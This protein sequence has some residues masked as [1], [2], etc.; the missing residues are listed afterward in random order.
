MF[1]QTR[2]SLWREYKRLTTEQNITKSLKYIK[3]SSQELLD[4][5]NKIKT[6]ATV[7]LSSND[8][9]HRTVVEKRRLARDL[10]IARYKLDKT[11]NP[12]SQ[13][14]ERVNKL[15][16]TINQPNITMERLGL[17]Y[18]TSSLADIEMAL[19]WLNKS[20]KERATM[21]LP[22]L[23]PVIRGRNRETHLLWVELMNLLNVN[24]DTDISSIPVNKKSSKEDIQELIQRIRNGEYTYNIS[25]N[26]L[27]IERNNELSE[28]SFAFRTFDKLTRE[29]IMSIIES[30]FR[31]TNI[32]SRT[33]VD[34]KIYHRQT[35][36]FDSSLGWIKPQDFKMSY[37]KITKAGT[38]TQFADLPLYSDA[39]LEYYSL[40]SG[41]QWKQN[42]CVLNMLMT[43][44][45]HERG[46]SQLTRAVLE[47][48]LGT[49]SPSANQLHEWLKRKDISHILQDPLNNVLLRYVSTHNNVKPIYGKIINSHI[50]TYTNDDTINAL[51]SSAD[52][53][54]CLRVDYSKSH[55]IHN[56]FYDMET[57]FDCIIHDILSTCESTKDN[58]STQNV[59]IVA[60]G[61]LSSLNDVV[62]YL[63]K[64]TGVCCEN[65]YGSSNKISGFTYKHLFVEISAWGASESII[66]AIKEKHPNSLIEYENQ[67]VSKIAEFIFSQFIKRQ[68]SYNKHTEKY[69]N[70]IIPLIQNKV[71]VDN[72][73]PSARAYDIAKCYKSCFMNRDEPFY[74]VNASDD[75][76]KVDFTEFPEQFKLGYYLIESPKPICLS[77]FSIASKNTIG[78]Y[79]LVVRS[80]DL[81]RLAE[82]G[83]ITPRDIK[84]FLA[85]R[86]MLN[87]SIAREMVNYIDELPINSPEAKKQIF[88]SYTGTLGKNTCKKSVMNC[89]TDL[90]SVHALLSEKVINTYKQILG[91]E[92]DMTYDKH[93]QLYLIENTTET[94][95]EK[96]NRPIY[97][98][99]LIS[100]IF[101]LERLYKAL[102]SP[103]SKVLYYKTDCICMTHTKCITLGTNA[104]DYREEQIKEKLVVSKEDKIVDYIQSPTDWVDISKYIDGN[105]YI[106][107]MYLKALID[108]RISF[109][110]Q[111]KGGRGK[112]HII[113]KLMKHVKC[114]GLTL[115]HQARIQLT[116]SGI[117]NSLTF[118]SFFATNPSEG[119]N[120][121]VD[122]IL[123]KLS[124]IDYIVV[125]ELS[126]VSSMF[127]NEL[128]MFWKKKQFNVIML[129]D[130]HQLCPPENG[131]RNNFNTTVVKEMCQYR[132]IELL[133]NYRS[134]ERLDKIAE[135]A[136]NGSRIEICPFK[137]AHTLKRINIC[138]TNARRKA[139]NDAC[140]ATFCKERDELG[141][142]EGVPFI[143]R[144]NE[145]NINNG[146]RYL[147]KKYSNG[148]VHL[149]S[150]FDNNSTLDLKKE[151]FKKIFDLAYCTTVHCAQGAT[152]N[153]EYTIHELKRFD[154][155]LA[156]TAF[157]RATKLENIYIDGSW[158]EIF[159]ESEDE[160]STIDITQKDKEMSI[161]TLGIRAFTKSNTSI[162]RKV[163]YIGQ[164]N[165]TENRFAQHLECARDVNNH[166]QVYEF[167]R[168]INTDDIDMQIVATCHKDNSDEFEYNVINYY[169]EHGCDLKNV[170]HAMAPRAKL[171]IPQPS[172]KPICEVKLKGW[173]KDK[174][175]RNTFEFRYTKDGKTFSIRRKYDKTNTENKS[176]VYNEMLEI[177]RKYSVEGIL[178]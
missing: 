110:V 166:T 19:N 96:S 71:F 176:K 7:Q 120:K 22:K 93:K 77:I 30:K 111:G 167:M 26:G 50:Y 100:G 39:P 122:R 80:K 112:T 28:H 177:Q 37:V 51:R 117:N 157:T 98:D 153:E 16:K 49:T 141:F 89:T 160:N 84:M 114:I 85:P 38:N 164:T 70:N 15:V 66:E 11:K 172:E 106:D 43:H 55:I 58:S 136:Y 107:E 63:Y 174:T 42:E 161:Y 6:P 138:Y 169:L 5:I 31:S 113:G 126:M 135:D 54:Q 41:I 140:L 116:K 102:V 56:Q 72:I 32:D 108:E 103:K 48:E 175:D 61:K 60:H 1:K 47:Q 46:F 14:W 87:E 21:Q 125:D 152:I 134:D 83:C 20:K 78:T 88:N 163:F 133:H 145:G 57:S 69:F 159:H 44:L 101:A 36:L 127:M 165:N 149:V 143:A 91:V 90:L 59:F 142:G 156:Y 123:N 130:Y 124:A 75:F 92:E 76:V 27:R 33:S 29:K 99:I 2:A 9:K 79:Q 168:T 24:D 53:V 115:S 109:R 147:Y 8:H 18:I 65:I 144:L 170:Q 150:S 40:S 45:Q 146:D 25:L 94:R 82:N 155:R 10:T 23:K 4:A 154:R 13:M 97:N 86:Y 121:Y 132:V 64:S 12:K 148:F 68:S 119:Y 81:Q 52:G 178:L 151:V 173:I 162:T 118:A 67:S 62:A 73:E 35:L 74:F 95:L 129:G 137:T 104:G 158:P 17:N 171:R 105:D 128:Y 3:S 131:S 139:V 34:F